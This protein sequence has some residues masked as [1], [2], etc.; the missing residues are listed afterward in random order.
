VGPGVGL[1]YI[2]KIKLLT[3]PGLEFRVVSPSSHSQALYL[4]RLYM[5]K[6]GL[7]KQESS[8]QRYG[9]SK[10]TVQSSLQSSYVIGNSQ[11]PGRQKDLLGCYVSTCELEY[12]HIQIHTI[13]NQQLRLISRCRVRLKFD[14]HLL[15]LLQGAGLISC[16]LWDWNLRA[17]YIERRAS[18]RCVCSTDTRYIYNFGIQSLR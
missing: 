3:L 1:D 5:W 16:I 17:N 4:L 11:E 10:G 12:S 6:S 9:W 18:E 8:W 13:W 14:S 7:F 15:L 2:E